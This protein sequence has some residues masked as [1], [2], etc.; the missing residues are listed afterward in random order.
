MGPPFQALFRRQIRVQQPT[1]PLGRRH[2]S[3]PGGLRS[4]HTPGG[5]RLE[6]GQ[7][8]LYVTLFILARCELGA[9]WCA[10]VNVQIKQK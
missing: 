9:N 3:R 4:Y 8:I 1:E 7:P 6:D 2:A 5:G 10:V